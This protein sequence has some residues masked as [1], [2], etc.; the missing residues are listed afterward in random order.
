MLMSVGLKMNEN[1][2]KCQVGN[3][4]KPEKITNVGRKTL[5]LVED[6]LY[7]RAKIGKTDGD[8][9]EKKGKAWVVCH[10]LISVWKL[11]LCKDLKIDLLVAAVESVM[12]YGCCDLD[13]DQ[14][15]HLDDEWVLH[16]FA[17]HG[18]EH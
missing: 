7:L 5:E 6:L 2:M 18:S 8:I 16:E 9:I 12:L 14:E 4:K 13:T 15:P 10:S 3:I 1:K 17:G 11:D